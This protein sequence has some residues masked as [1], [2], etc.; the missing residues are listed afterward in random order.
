MA[1]YAAFDVIALKD[2]LGNVYKHLDTLQNEYIRV[3]ASV[4]FMSDHV[5]PFMLK[6]L[7]REL[8]AVYDIAKAVRDVGPLV[9]DK[10]LYCCAAG[11]RHAG[12]AT[13]AQVIAMINQSAG[14][15]MQISNMGSGS[16]TTGT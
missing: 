9:A 16:S 11:R 13:I 10:R 14:T 15:P 5:Q 4:C 3:G 7:R 12:T 8:T 2:T 1:R 6:Q